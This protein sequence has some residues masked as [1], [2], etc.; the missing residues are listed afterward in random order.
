VGFGKIVGDAS[1]FPERG[2]LST[3]QYATD[4]LCS[5]SDFCPSIVKFFEC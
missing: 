2:P 4:N 1:L 5:S 3:P